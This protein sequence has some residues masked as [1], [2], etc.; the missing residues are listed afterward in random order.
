VV[1]SACKPTGKTRG[2]Y[3][4]E[5]MAFILLETIAWEIGICIFIRA[6]GVDVGL[7]NEVEAG[8]E[9]V[10]SSLEL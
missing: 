9:G 5:I 3:L 7:D 1:G 10:C 6:I 8:V 4:E 2:A